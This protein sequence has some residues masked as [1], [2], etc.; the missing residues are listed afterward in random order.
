M[1][2]SKSIF[3]NLTPIVL[4]LVLTLFNPIQPKQ[5][6]DKYEGARIQNRPEN[7][8]YLTK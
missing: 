8:S 2:K 4:W 3:E 5:P 1:S 7:K 6:L